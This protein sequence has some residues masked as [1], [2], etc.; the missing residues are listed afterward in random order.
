M[1]IIRNHTPL[2]SRKGSNSSL[3]SHHSSSSHHHAHKTGQASTSGAAG[4]IEKPHTLADLA[5]RAVGDHPHDNEPG[6]DNLHQRFNEGGEHP[7][8][9]RNAESGHISHGMPGSALTGERRR[10]LER[11][12]KGKGKAPRM[13]GGDDDHS[14]NEH[15][16]DALQKAVGGNFSNGHDKDTYDSDPEDLSG[17][18]RG[19]KIPRE[20]IE[21]EEIRRAEKRLEQHAEENQE[22][23]HLHGHTNAQEGQR[24]FLN[25]DVHTGRQPTGQEASF[26]FTG[27]RPE[28]AYVGQEGQG[29][30]DGM[31]DSNASSNGSGQPGQARGMQHGG[32][33]EN[34]GQTDHRTAEEQRG[35]MNDKE[36]EQ[37]DME[38]L[39]PRDPQPGE[40]GQVPDGMAA[41]KE[42]ERPGPRNEINLNPRITKISYHTADARELHL[43]ADHVPLT[44]SA[45]GETEDL[46]NGKS[47]RHAADPEDRWT[48]TRTRERELIGVKDR[49][50][51][52][53]AQYD[54]ERLMKGA[55]V[56]PPSKGGFVE[57]SRTYD[58]GDE[59]EDSA[60]SSDEER[61]LR[62][63]GDDDVA[64]LNGN[65]N[66]TKRANRPHKPIPKADPERKAEL[67]S[68][69]DSPAG[70]RP[71]NQRIWST[72]RRNKVGTTEGES[73]RPTSRPSSVHELQGAMDAEKTYEEPKSTGQQ[74]WTVL[75][76]KL[77]HRQS[78]AV[79]E[80]HSSPAQIP[81]TTELLAGQL[82]AMILK[83]WL[84]RDENGSRS[85]PVLLGSLRFR[86]GDSAGFNNS[87]NGQQTGRE[88]FRIECE[89][90]DGAVKWV[91]NDSVT[92]ERRQ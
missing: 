36:K 54:D 1:D 11:E 38:R 30:E 49:E 85:V 48:S 10:D 87:N 37:D 74:K 56:G 80:K 72:F 3:R 33:G 52:E 31:E 19:K 14:E 90:G 39:P 67:M 81:V 23:H 17:H 92:R 20:K 25:P 42:E 75:R 5:H 27:H 59:E 45:D 12:K 65:G 40:T 46:P 63:E 70:K 6:H 4:H 71:K 82:P 64:S 78:T 88:V 8:L 86:V 77:L 21:R 79:H 57:G 29:Q 16:V 58:Y 28:H 83:T 50:G 47:F 91:G 32:G 51:D 60:S 84:D 55:H 76:A 69:N 24:K 62:E 43:K 26:P 53:N 41:T 18:A 89:Y 13:G 35:K 7:G 61:V 66:G 68:A 2:G 9:D 44:V 22:A 15:A 73:S 34:Q